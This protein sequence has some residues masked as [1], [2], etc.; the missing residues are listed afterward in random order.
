MIKRTTLLI[1]ALL[2]DFAVPAYAEDDF[3]ADSRFSELAESLKQEEKKT[4]KKK[5]K[6]KKNEGDWCKDLQDI[7]VIYKNKKNPWVQKVTVFGRIQNNWIYSDGDDNGRDFSNYGSELRRFRVGA[8]I[9]FLN[10]FTLHG[11]INLEDGELFDNETAHRDFN[12]L[13]LKYKWEDVGV[14]KKITAGYGLEKIVFGG[15]WY[16]TSKEIKTVERSNLSQFFAPDRATG[17]FFSTETK[18]WEIL[19]GVYSSSE[20]G[21]ALA[22]WNGGQG[23]FISA[24]RDLGKKRNLRGDFVYVDATDEEDDIFGYDW[25]GS[26]NYDIDLG[27]WDLFVNATYGSTDRGDVY[28]VVIMPSTFIIKK[29]LE[30]VF[31]YQWAGSDGQTLRPGS[32]THTSVRTIAESDGVGIARG[33]ESHTFYAG[34]NYHFCDDNL[35]LLTGI[36]YE[37]L[38]GDNADTE[39]VTLW[40]SI[41]FFF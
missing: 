38:D 17:A 36:E 4:K 7:G 23:Y 33:D 30:A 31:R 1:A 13:S 27:K 35:K 20:Q 11:R 2:A 6:K 9:E 19:F 14:F 32:G 26:L 22:S 41:R 12:E 15:E 28:G 39:A 3:T 18:D 37:T 34:L 5:K 21:Y 10:G 8:D 40:S 25:A 24:K 16:Y 29:K